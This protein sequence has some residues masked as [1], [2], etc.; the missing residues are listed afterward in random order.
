MGD[1][2]EETPQ[3]AIVGG[4][5]AGKAAAR[6][7]RQAGL[8]VTIFEKEAAL[9]GLMRFGYPSYRMPTEVTER[10][11]ASL[12]DSGVEVRHGQAIGENLSLADLQT[13]F[14]AVI[15][16]VGAP[17][18]HQLG[19]PG[20]E[21]PGVWKALDFLYR[22]RVGEIDSV[23]GTVVVIGG[24][25]TALDAA[26]SA[27]TLGA[28]AVT[29]HYRGEEAGLRGLAHERVRARQAGVRLDFHRV[30]EH[31][32]RTPD[33]R[34]AIRYPQGRESADRVIIAIGQGVDREWF[35]KLG[36]RVAPDGTSTNL[37]GVFVAGG[38]SYGSDR[39][40]KAI[41]GGR[42]AAAAV[43]RLLR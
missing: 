6:E 17:R 27:K 15:L 18:P 43:T 32:I 14:D 38:A 33:G 5:P 16:A 10:E 41:L 29:I 28:E 37:P 42:A 30:P 25:D 4:G 21:L 26:T 2:S 11:S 39:L 7:L 34:L 36:V 24:G 19:I 35:A 31:I 9:G 23:S 1:S 40:A 8:G 20:E 3:V 22:V 12:L 13:E